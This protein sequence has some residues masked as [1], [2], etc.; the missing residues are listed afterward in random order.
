MKHTS[1]SLLS[2]FSVV[3]LC[4]CT[5]DRPAE[6]PV[7]APAAKI[8]GEAVQCI[9]LTQIRQTQIRDDWTIDFIGTGDKVWRNTLPNRCSG[10]KSE[11]AFTYKTSLSQLCSTDIIYVLRHIGGDL[12]R[13]PG[14]GLGKF[15]PVELEKKK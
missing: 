4:G 5:Q 14:C 9:P 15:V 3:A 10:L 2:A 1:I 12:Q 8:T 11:D 7:V 6:R 13:G